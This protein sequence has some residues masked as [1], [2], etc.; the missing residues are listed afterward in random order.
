[1]ETTTNFALLIPMVVAFLGILGFLA[2]LGFRG[3]K[4]HED[5]LLAGKEI[6][7]FMMAMS[8]GAAFVSTA[9]IIGFGGLSG[10][11]GFSL[12]WI[13]FLNIFIGIFI[14]Y[15]LFGKR[16]RQ[17]GENL[18]A[19]T[20]PDFMA[21]RFLNKDVRSV[22]AWVIIVF[23]PLYAASVV[24]GASRFI[25]TTF[26]M[27]FTIAAIIYVAIVAI[28]VV[29]GGLK[30]VIYA[31]AFLGS[32]MLAAMT[33]L[34]IFA[35]VKLGG[36]VPAHS[37]LTAL[38][39]LV[40]EKLAAAGHQGWTAF[41]AFN[42]G[43]WWTSISSLMMGVGLGVL[44]QPQLLV[45]FMTVKDNKQLNRAVLIGGIFILF[46][47]GTAYVVGALSNVFFFN[48][49]G[50]TAIQKVTETSVVGGVEKVLIN[51]D[52]IMPNFIN[53][54]TSQWYV[55][56]FLLCLMSAAIS[57]SAAQFHTIGSALGNDFFEDSLGL[58]SKKQVLLWN[59]VGIFVSIV[60]TFILGIWLL[61]PGIVG[62]A[63]AFFFS[64]A[65]A[66]FLGPTIAALFWRRATT[67]GV[68]AS[69]LVGLGVTIAWALLVNE[70]ISTAFGLTPLLPKPFSVMD[71]GMIGLPLSLIALFVVSYLTKPLPKEHTDMCFKK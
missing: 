69:M 55:Y 53:Q 21:K 15:T 29:T 35:Y 34:L 67:Q 7:P 36:I 39:S 17:I 33:F 6:N 63:T 2:W 42:S 51:I 28:Y 27:D 26:K 30:S 16:M 25:E 3:T 24:V 8:Y 9:A 61:P 66:T 4:T 22:T 60:I 50:V 44:A 57:T 64:I 41:P 31:D 12:M 5:Y 65:A 58:K 62:S 43:I 48:A 54:F 56:L 32:I 18:K 37:Q 20:F 45:R 68:M 13:V 46:V 59:R 23:M 40:P 38:S 1:M 11:F 70:K 52:K 47:V 49:E 10:Q 71:S 14:A 19:K